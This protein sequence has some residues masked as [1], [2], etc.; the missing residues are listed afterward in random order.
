MTFKNK[1]TT[2]IL[3]KNWK[4]EEGEFETGRDLEVENV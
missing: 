3:S 4:R 1:I 2:E